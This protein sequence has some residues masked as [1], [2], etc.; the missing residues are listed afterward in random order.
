MNT[1]NPFTPPAA[2]I[3]GPI[4]HTGNPALDVPPAVI[5][6]LAETRPWLRLMLG[7]F[8]TGIVLMAF[9]VLGVGALAWFGHRG[10]PS[11][12]ALGMLV[13]LLFVAL[14]YAPPAVYLARAAN[15]IRRLQAG[16]GWPA[17]EEALRSQKCLWKYLGILVLVIIALYA[18][19]FVLVK[20]RGFGG[21]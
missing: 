1:P 18:L 12:T 21:G 9:A 7:L 16:G 14:I 13:P 2:N 10:R 19:A 3:D 17:L 5:A 4:P 6:I 20:A 11:S 8:V 15:G